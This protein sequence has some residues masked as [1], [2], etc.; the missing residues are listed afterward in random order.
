MLGSLTARAQ[1]MTHRAEPM[2]HSHSLQARAGTINQI[3]HCC[4]TL[5]GVDA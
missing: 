5:P 1:P 2:T 3:V 4:A